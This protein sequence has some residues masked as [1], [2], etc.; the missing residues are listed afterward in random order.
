MFETCAVLEAIADIAVGSLAG[1]VLVLEAAANCTDGEVWRQALKLNNRYK[2]ERD[3]FIFSSDTDT[4]FVGETSQSIGVVLMCPG[5]N[6]GGDLNKIS[7][8]ANWS[9]DISGIGSSKYL[10]FTYCNID[11]DV[12]GA[13]G[14]FG[15]EPRFLPVLA[16]CLGGDLSAY[17]ADVRRFTVGVK[18]ALVNA[19][20]ADP[21]VAKAFKSLT[22]QTR[23]EQ[24]VARTRGRAG[25]RSVT[26]ECKYGKFCRK[27]ECTFSHP[28]GARMYCK[29]EESGRCTRPGCD[30]RHAQPMAFEIDP[31]LLNAHGLPCP[32]EIVFDTWGEAVKALLEVQEKQKKVAHGVGRGM[33]LGFG[34]KHAKALNHM[35]TRRTTEL[36][37]EHRGRWTT[38][39]GKLDIETCVQDVCAWLPNVSAGSGGQDHARALRGAIKTYDLPPVEE[40]P[41]R[42]SVSTQD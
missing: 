39:S 42:V 9:C 37:K 15:V 29:S 6:N 8:G 16:A 13:H 41:L 20:F 2:G 18:S 21:D 28:R 11:E 40:D 27:S 14:A 3:T 35:I 33:P 31:F 24:E 12:A 23:R 25:S 22:N 32:D 30:Y 34:L 4:L 17:D 19:H 38:D 5:A 1:Q 26:W 36:V 10:R 7:R